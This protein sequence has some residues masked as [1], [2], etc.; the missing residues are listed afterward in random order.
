VRGRTIAAFLLVW[1]LSACSQSSVPTAAPTVAACGTPSPRVADP[2][3]V[4]APGNRLGPLMIVSGFAASGS[5]TPELI[6][7]P[8]KVLIHP[9]APFDQPITLTGAR[10]SDG[11]PVRF[12]YGP[13]HQGTPFV[14]GPQS[15]PVPEAVL[16]QT[17]ELR[18]DI[19]PAPKSCGSCGAGLDYTG[20]MLFTTT[21]TWRVRGQSGGRDIGEII[22]LVGA[23]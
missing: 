11:Q 17:G 18:V 3:G 6:G 13:A 23:T 14:M 8:T 1:V 20:Y 19:E 5:P 7:A 21:G 2:T 16:A 9:A 12:W 15:T 22:I 4:T 10:C